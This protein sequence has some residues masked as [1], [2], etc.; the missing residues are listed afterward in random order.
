[1]ELSNVI[2]QGPPLEDA[3]ALDCLPSALK[4]L[5]LQINGFI[6]F[7]GGF[8]VRGIC[9][10]PE[11]HSLFHV[12]TGE[13]ALHNLYE[14]VKQSDVPFAQD[15]LGDQFL[16]RDCMVWKLSSETG[17]VES[18]NC[19]LWQFLDNVQNDPVEY[20]A[21]QPLVNFY[22]SGGELE[23]GQLLQA[24]PPFCVGESSQGVSLRAVSAL[25]HIRFL[26]DF[27]RQIADLPDGT[28][29]RLSPKE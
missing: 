21:L 25:E 8:H 20:L 15:A 7:G 14:E 16:L 23:S 19:D 4:D 2:F 13:M 5:L 9:S 12:W 28:K 6:Q 10:E 17:Q 22:H 11:W 3:S 29:I 27:A 18:L 24:Y 1:M 26:S